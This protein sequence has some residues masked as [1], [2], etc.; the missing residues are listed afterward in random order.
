MLPACAGPPPTTSTLREPF[1]PSIINYRLLAR[2]WVDGTSPHSR[3]FISRFNV[4]PAGAI[5]VIA[6]DATPDLIS[7]PSLALLGNSGSQS[8]AC[9]GKQNPPCFNMIFSANRAVYAADYG[10]RDLRLLLDYCSTFDMTPW[11]S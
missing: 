1:A 10:H 9:Q 11:G 5:A 8:T 7:L 2:P 4:R 6:A 3:A